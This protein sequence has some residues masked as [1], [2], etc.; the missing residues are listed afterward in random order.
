MIQNAGSNDIV[1]LLGIT[2]EQI[3]DVFVSQEQVHI[4][5]TNG[6]FLQVQ[7]NTG[8]GYRLQDKTYVCNQSTG[9]WSTK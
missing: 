7:G 9:E 8:V 2:L 5:F 3:S 4:N 6:E 1:N